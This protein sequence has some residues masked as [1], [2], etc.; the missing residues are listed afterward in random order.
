MCL[1]VS[2]KNMLARFT[3]V[4]VMKWQTSSAFLPHPHTH[5]QANLFPFCTNT[6]MPIYGVAVGRLVWLEWRSIIHL[7][8]SLSKGHHGS[9]QRLRMFS[10][11]SLL[12]WTQRFHQRSQDSE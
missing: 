1:C 10:S 11:L 12:M 6:H 5:T 7:R 9:R 2:A 8:L 3:L 4:E